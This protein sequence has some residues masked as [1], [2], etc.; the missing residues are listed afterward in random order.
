MRFFSCA[1]KIIDIKSDVKYFQP[2][3]KAGDHR[4][5]Y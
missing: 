3:P 5:S 2:N 4:N 1:T